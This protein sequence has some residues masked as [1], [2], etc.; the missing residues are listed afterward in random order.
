MRVGLNIL[1]VAGCLNAAFA[2]GG[3]LLV[4]ADFAGGTWGYRD[5]PLRSEKWSRP[6]R[7]T[8]TN[9]V[10]R[11]DHVCLKTF[12][13]KLK[14]GTEY[15]VA[16]RVRN[17]D[18]AVPAEPCLMLL[19][20]AWNMV[21]NRR[22][23][24]EGGE[25]RDIRL[26]G[27]AKS[28]RYD[29]HYV[30]LDNP[31]GKGDLEVARLSLAEGRIEDW[32]ELPDGELL[33]D[34]PT[35]FPSGRADS[36]AVLRRNVSGRSG[37]I[38][39]T[40]SDARGRK[41][42][43]RD[44]DYGTEKLARFVLPIAA[45]HPRG[46]FTVTAS[47]ANELRYA[48]QADLSALRCAYNPL[49]GHFYA[50]RGW[51]LGWYNRYMPITGS[52]N[53]QF[54]PLTSFED[55]ASMKAL[56]GL[57][58]D[59]IL[60]L[61]NWKTFTPRGECPWTEEVKRDQL[62]MLRRIAERVRGHRVDGLELFN[63]P[64]LW[65][66]RTGP[67]AGRKTMDADK[68]AKL[69]EEIVPEMKRGNPDLRIVGPCC[70]LR[71]LD[72]LKHFLDAGG[73]RFID[74]VSIHSY[75]VDPD[76]DDFAEQYRRLRA[77][78][79]EA[80][81]RDLPVYNTEAYLGLRNA[82]I[83]AE[84]EEARRGYFKDGQWAHASVTAAMLVHHAVAQVGWANYAPQY[85]ISGL[86]NTDRLYATVSLP[87]INAAVAFLADCGPG[88]EVKLVPGVHCHLFRNATGGPLATLR[89]RIHEPV[90][91]SGFGAL[92]TYDMFG[93]RTCGDVR[94]L[95]DEVA[96]IRFA[97]GGDAVGALKG[98]RFFGL[99]VVAERDRPLKVETY[100]VA[101]APDVKIADA[102]KVH[103]GAENLSAAFTPGVT[104]KGEG[105]L[106][107]DLAAVWSEAGLKLRVVVKD[108]V[109]TY[110]SECENA[111]RADSLQVY[112]DMRNDATPASEEAGKR[113]EDDVVYTIAALGGTRPTAYVA[114]ANG[115]R[116]LGAANETTG[117][118]VD[119]TVNYAYRHGRHVYD[120]FF[121]RMTLPDFRFAPGEVLGFSLLVNDA[122]A[123]GKRGQGLTL[124]SPGAEPSG[125]ADSFIDFRLVR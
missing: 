57:G 71:E 59:T 84:D 37:R 105:D 15:T 1:T 66:I 77:M 102:K 42:F 48:V 108:D 86:L 112:F 22:L 28:S 50:N 115:G 96:Y 52:V 54:F 43:S 32:P 63:E 44:F 14:P 9:G 29:L 124:T 79:R 74:A 23:V 33:P 30:R 31:S 67:E 10:L 51:D 87:A 125:R 4:N 92:E 35:L 104:W 89:V 72:Y 98:L 61:T 118:D 97:P 5:Y 16:M 85:A 95:S 11:H 99:E 107:A 109:C 69:H 25:W 78:V 80:V 106:S 53:R 70:A 119:V 113:R 55:D 65:R 93:N 62:P 73:G 8:V 19:D 114:F 27:I 120:I 116:Y 12:N 75:T 3:E 26:H 21:A 47:G 64:F 56:D 90:K 20:G 24:L 111:Y 88:E 101:Y 94:M 17:V 46:L 40:V 58:F 76:V 117:I 100:E 81:G 83:T 110:P 82:P 7:P 45:D 6:P 34:G 122:D 18:P 39:L 68:V 41:L 123:T 121:P 13:V 103:L 38:V 2:V 49:A 36:F 91:V 60:C